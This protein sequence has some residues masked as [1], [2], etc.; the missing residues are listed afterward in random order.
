[1]PLKSLA[2]TDA[3]HEKMKEG[4]AKCC[5]MPSD[6]VGPK[7]PW[8]LE[9]SFDNTVLEKMG[10]QATDFKPGTDM[11]ITGTLRITGMNINENEDGSKHQSVRAVLTAI[12]DGQEP[13]T[14][15]ERATAIYGSSET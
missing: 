8:G 7:Y 14:D 5:S 3:D 12:D 11:P 2:Y 1:M 15:K 13:K 6:Y 9:L 10:K 4:M